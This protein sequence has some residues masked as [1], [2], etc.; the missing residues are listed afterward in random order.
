ML[1]ANWW[2]RPEKPST[3]KKKIKIKKHKPMKLSVRK[4]IEFCQGNWDELH[5]IMITSRTRV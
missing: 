3:V 1:K 4:T 2:Q 5:Y